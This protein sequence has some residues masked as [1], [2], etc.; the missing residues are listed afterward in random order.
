MKYKSVVF[1]A[2]MATPCAGKSYLCD[3][4]PDKF[5]DMDEVRLKCKYIVPE[6]I[7]RE[8]LERTKG[9]RTFEKAKTKDY[10]K[11]LYEKLDIEVKNGKVLIASPHPECYEYFK[12]R[13]IKFCLV[14]AN[15]DMQKEIKKRMVGRGNSA[16]TTKENFD[17]F[18][19]FY[20]KNIKDN[21]PSI[22]Y[23]FKKGEYLED[24]LK[25]FGYK[26]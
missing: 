1:E 21:A 23:A 6:N 19:T 8:E 3:K 15:F 26:F 18:K 20:E 2:V 22:K 11:D 10:I 7:T 24:I 12:T 14:Y 5:V 9:N 16:E 4:Y 25:K 13:N 17:L